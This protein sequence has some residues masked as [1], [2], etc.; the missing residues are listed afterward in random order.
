[1]FLAMEMFATYQLQRQLL[2]SSHRL[3]SSSTTSSLNWQVKAHKH[4]TMAT[5]PVQF[6]L[7]IISLWCVSSSTEEWQTLQSTPIK[8]SQLRLSTTWRRR[9]SLAS[10]GLS[11]PRADGLVQITAYSSLNWRWS[12]QIAKL[13]FCSTDK[14][15]V[16]IQFWGDNRSLR[17]INHKSCSKSK[18][19]LQY[20]FF[21]WIHSSVA[22]MSVI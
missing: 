3:Q 4:T 6:S 20:I 7:A 15:M 12:D 16:Q 5:L 8:L 11:C 22:G 18:L 9:Y 13:H 17:T 2:L 14:R 19:W 21:E 1:M 10:T